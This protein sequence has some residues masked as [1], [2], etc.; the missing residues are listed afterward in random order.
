MAITCSIS[1]VVIGR[2]EAPLPD[3]KKPQDTS[4]SC[5]SGLVSGR[6]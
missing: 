2:N 1:A 5:G 3:A 6:L 4:L